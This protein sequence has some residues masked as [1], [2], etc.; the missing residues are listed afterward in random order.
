MS[1]HLIHIGYA[2]AGSHFVRHWFR[3]HPQLDFM[4]SGIAGFRN[5][6]DLARRSVEPSR[7]VRWRVT[8]AEELASPRPNLREIVFDRDWGGPIPEA[9]ARARDILAELFPG[10]TILLLTRGFRTLLLSGYSEYVREGGDRD[11]LDMLARGNGSGDQRGEHAW[12]YDYLIGLYR[13]AFGERVIVLPYELLSADSSAFL[14]VLE[15]RLG[16]DRFELP[17]ERLYPSLSPVEL[18]WYPRITRVVRRLPLRGRVR[19]ALYRRYVRGVT[20]N[21]W[22]RPIGVLQRLFPRTPVTDS[23]ISDANVEFFRGRADSL[24]HDPVYAPYAQEYLF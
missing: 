14:R 19:D 2:K 18:C 3:A 9:Q 7:D 10:A 20:R 1:G 5:V 12:N 8:S 21:A 15:A 6:F 24:R 16:V 23:L 4:H 17:T 11:F 13:A 22:A